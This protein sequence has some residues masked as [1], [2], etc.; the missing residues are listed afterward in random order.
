M[1]MAVMQKWSQAKVIRFQ[2]AGIHKARTGVVFGDYE[3]KADVTDRMTVEYLFDNKTRK[4]VGEPK[5]VDFPSETANIKADGT[6]CP[7][8]Q[9]KG[10]Y[11]HF[12][13]VKSAVMGTQIQVTGNRIFPA[14][15]VSQY[16]ASCGMKSV[17]GG[18]VE[19]FLFVTIMDARL[20]GMPI[21]TGNKNMAVAADRKSFTVAGAENWSWTYTPSVVE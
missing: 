3:G 7:P 8:P 14:A 4:V 19:K 12:K 9:L 16:P 1:D 15:S 13:M 18:T 6:N 11:E 21:Q 10:A 17:P 5:I 2:V 20:L